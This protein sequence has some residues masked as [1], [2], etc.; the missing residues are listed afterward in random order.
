LLALLLELLATRKTPSQT[1]IQSG[2]HMQIGVESSQAVD[3]K[4]VFVVDGDEITRAA[5][6]FM[7]HDENETHEFAELDSALR[8]AADWRPDLLILSGALVLAATPDL[9]AGLKA[10]IAGLKVLVA[11]EGGTTDART[12]RQAGADGVLHKPLTIEK[13]RMAVDVALGRRRATIAIEPA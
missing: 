13:A 9:I 7:L 11:I 10:R 2:G 8:K 12:L 6:Q 5:L 1:L 4:R 3:N